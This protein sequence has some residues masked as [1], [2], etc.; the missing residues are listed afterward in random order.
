MNL[1]NRLLLSITL[2]L[3]SSLASAQDWPSYGGDNG[4]GKYLPLDQI[5]AQNV[6][7]LVVAWSWDSVDNET[8]AANLAAGDDRESPSPYP[9]TPLV[10]DGVR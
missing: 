8:V 10:V 2:A 6:G 7:A 1:S 5:T 3:T 9:A 4:S